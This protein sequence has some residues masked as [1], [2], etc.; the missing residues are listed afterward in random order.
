M[1]LKAVVAH[2]SSRRGLVDDLLA[3]VA[4][5][6]TVHGRL[7]RRRPAVACGNSSATISR[8]KYRISGSRPCLRWLPNAK[9][10]RRRS[11][12]KPQKHGQWQKHRG[13]SS[14]GRDGSARP[15]TGRIGGD[16][17][18]CGGSQRN[19]DGEMQAGHADATSTASAA[20]GGMLGRYGMAA[21]ACGPSHVS[22]SRAMGQGT[23]S[24]ARRQVR[25]LRLA[26]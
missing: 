19:G 9:A 25:Q 17:R 18:G 12:A 16:W 7:P 4:L 10:M 3:L 23:V 20:A 22:G 8:C 2:V 24:V 1:A 14:H 15:W 21:M 26:A 6:C 5:A 11:E 13:I